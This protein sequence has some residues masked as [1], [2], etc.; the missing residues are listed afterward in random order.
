MYLTPRLKKLSSSSREF[1]IGF[2]FSIPII[3][4]N[5]PFSLFKS[6]SEGDVAIA[7]TL[8]FDS[9]EDNTAANILFANALL[10]STESDAEV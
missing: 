6:A 2:P 1:P 8:E 3:T 4:E 9:T 7:A 10:S 5:N